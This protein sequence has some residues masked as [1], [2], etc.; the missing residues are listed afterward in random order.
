MKLI[1]L[2]QGM[3]AQVDDD[4][5]D[6]L[7]QWKW[8]AHKGGKTYYAIRSSKRIGGKQTTIQ[9]HRLI[10]NTPD[11]QEVDHGDH[12]GL[13]C[14]R[15][16]MRNATRS[17]NKMNVTTFSNSGFLGVYILKG[18]TRK[19]KTYRNTIIAKIQVKGK[20][21]YLGAFST[22]ELAAL[23]YNE[24]A[25]IHHREFANLNII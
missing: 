20:S 5:Y 18:Q 19:G 25:K 6:W 12:N 9:M 8:Y 24:A 14:Q 15:H 10:M 11:D 21:L 16:N 22:P 13:N 7:N 2:T 17:Q 1:K 4:N 3:F 23:A